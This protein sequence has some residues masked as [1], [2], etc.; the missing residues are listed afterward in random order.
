VEHVDNRMAMLLR[1]YMYQ[2][3]VSMAIQF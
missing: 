2:T 1:C 3:F